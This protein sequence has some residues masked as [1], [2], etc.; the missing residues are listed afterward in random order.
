M[1]TEVWEVYRRQMDEYNRFMRDQE[2][3]WEAEEER[4]RMRDAGEFYNESPE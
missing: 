2:A 1:T 3:A 4:Q